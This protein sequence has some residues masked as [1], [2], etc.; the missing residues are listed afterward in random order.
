MAED[1]DDKYGPID[2][3][4]RRHA[5]SEDAARRAQRTRDR[6]EREQR[7]LAATVEALGISPLDNTETIEHRI[8]AAGLSVM[9]ISPDGRGWYYAVVWRPR[10][11]QTAGE[12]DRAGSQSI[13]E[14]PSEALCHAA[15]KACI[16]DPGDGPPSA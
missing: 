12:A 6:L 16:A 13:G 1:E 7:D 11:G 5:Q 15:A 4:K 14:S 3:D 10:P 8:A 9:G 2:W